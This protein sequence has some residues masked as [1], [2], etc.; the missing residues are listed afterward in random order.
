[1]PKATACPQV[2]RQYQLTTL[3]YIHRCVISCRMS[4]DVI[5]RR[6]QSRL[7]QPRFQPSGI[8]NVSGM[9]VPGVA[10]PNSGNP[11]PFPPNSSAHIHVMPNG[12]GPMQNPQPGQPSHQQPLP[13][14]QGPPLGFPGHA[15]THPNGIAP[16]SGPRGPI[17]GP[18]APGQPPRA[19]GFYQSPTMAHPHTPTG[20]GQPPYPGSNWNM[21]GGGGNAQTRVMPP[22]GAQPNGAANAASPGFGQG[23][24]GSRA[25]TPA[26]TGGM[27]QSSPGM[28]NR[29]TPQTPPSFGGPQAAGGRGPSAEQINAEFAQI[30]PRT[31]HDLRVELGFVNKDA[32][33]MTIEEKVLAFACACK[34]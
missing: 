28:A 32:S 18:G 26:Q 25:P 19:P 14:Q 21:I 13:P 2:Q 31:L 33:A 11:G 7:Q 10:G 4:S 27:V 5:P 23:G 6:L 15:Q 20:N 3:Y 8:R 17:T 34:I 22:P 9:G 1:M 30:S 12:A 16:Q 29:P 24:P